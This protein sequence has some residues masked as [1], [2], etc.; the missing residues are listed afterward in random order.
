MNKNAKH[1]EKKRR[2]KLCGMQLVWKPIDK[3]TQEKNEKR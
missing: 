3:F 1:E 2:E